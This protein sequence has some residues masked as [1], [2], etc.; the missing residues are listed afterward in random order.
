[1][2]TDEKR[3]YLEEIDDAD[4][5][6]PELRL[7]TQVVRGTSIERQSA[8]EIG[9]E[10]IGEHED[11]N[12]EVYEKILKSIPENTQ[13]DTAIHTDSQMLSVE[14]DADSRVT[15]LV[16]LAESK[17]VVHAVK[18]AKN[19]HNNYQLDMLHA[20]LSAEDVRDALVK[21]GFLKSE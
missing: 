7:D 9:Q 21:K 14:M 20:K 10:S 8:S 5:K 16:D 6:A 18:V 17:G 3:S 2:A 12:S 19:L 4:I 11:R 1:M 15:Q 13:H